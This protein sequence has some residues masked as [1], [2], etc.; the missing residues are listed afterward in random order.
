MARLFVLLAALLPA[1]ITAFMAPAVLPRAGCS[2]RAL[3]EVGEK[4]ACVCYEGIM[5]RSPLLAYISMA[6]VF[7]CIYVCMCGRERWDPSPNT[8]E[9]GTGQVG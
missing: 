9:E 1:V 4:S 5:S 8:N 7:I 6:G 2:S 3:T